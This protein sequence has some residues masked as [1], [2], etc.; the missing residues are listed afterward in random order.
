[1]GKPHQLTSR[2]RATSAEPE[3][4][5][6]KPP[7]AEIFANFARRKRPSLLIVCDCRGARAQDFPLLEPPGPGSGL[8]RARV[9]HMQ[10]FEAA[11][12]EACFSASVA[13][14]GR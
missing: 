9:I 12:G 3:P 13:Q 6:Q 5:D 2:Q 14:A 7:C 10:L 8:R 1:M 4:T 11:L